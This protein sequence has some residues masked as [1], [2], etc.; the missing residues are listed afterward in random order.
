MGTAI[1]R[2][3]GVSRE[4]SP[5]PPWRGHV[6][7]SSGSVKGLWISIISITGNSLEMQ[8]LRQAPDLLSQKFWSWTQKSVF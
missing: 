6:H 1:P 8:I 5:V 7:Q 4:S 3:L 2:V